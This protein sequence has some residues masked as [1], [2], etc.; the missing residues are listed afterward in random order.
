MSAG[1]QPLAQPLAERAALVSWKS[2]NFTVQVVAVQL[3]HRDTGTAGA[4]VNP[5]QQQPH[6][7]EINGSD[8]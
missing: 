1:L 3:L 5:V 8:V 7:L 4:A 2:E 6:N